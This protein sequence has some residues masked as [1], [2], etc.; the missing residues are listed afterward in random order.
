MKFSPVEFS[1][2]RP[3]LVIVIILLVTAAFATQFPRIKTDTDPNN[4][5]PENSDVRLSNREV[6]QTFGLHKDMM[7]VAVVNDTT[8]FNPGTVN[9]IATLTGEIQNISGVA[10]K[11][12][13]NMFIA[14]NMPASQSSFSSEQT[15]AMKAMFMNNP[16]MVG[17]FVSAD[18]KTTAVYVPLE[19]GANGKEV[20]DS[21]RQLVGNDQSGDTF[22]VAGDP[23]ARDTFG[24]Q[25]FLQMGLFSP[26][27]G[28]IMMLVL[29]L[30]F[31][32]WP[33]T[34]SVMGVAMI[35]I[36]WTLGLLIGLGYPVH[37]MSSMMP[38]FLMA[39]STASIHI[40]NEF[41]FCCG[42]MEE[43]RLAIMK[44]MKVVGPPVLFT[45]LVAAIGFAVLGVGNIIPV[46]VFGLF[47][48]FGIGV[49]ALLSFTF[50]PAVMTLAGE[51]SLRRAASR[52]VPERNR[53]GAALRRV[54]QFAVDKRVAVIVIGLLL[55]SLSI[56]GITKI[57]V[58]NNMVAWFKSGSDIRVADRVINDNL[59]GSSSAYLVAEGNGSGSVATPASLSYI[60]GLQKQLATLPVVGNTYSIA[61][62]VKM[63]NMMMDGNSPASFNLPS[64]QSQTAQLL[65]SAAKPSDITADRSQAAIQ[66]QLKT[67]DASAMD[68]VLD[69]TN[70]YI[71]AN[72]APSGIVFKPAGIAYFNK[73]WND[74]V[75]GDM[76]RVFIIGVSIIF[77]VLILVFRSFKWAVVSF[78][79]LLFTILIIYGAIG[80]IGKDLDMPI[81]VLS[82]LS[83][84]LA[85]DF[86][87]H[88][89]RR[90]RQRLKTESDIEQA[91]IWTV[92]RPGK[93]IIR[94]AILFSA[95]FSVMVFAALTPYITVG[96]FIMSIMMV[97]ALLT[98]V[99]LPAL[100]RMFNLK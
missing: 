1:V 87:I 80:F 56:W 55:V 44:T 17:R 15:Q 89:V 22:Y 96:V 62:S 5:L 3:V 83:L 34:L 46:R 8:V 78:I 38:V 57:R 36:V 41:Y 29:Y 31:R 51:R 16:L 58:N 73:I 91:L 69:K 100:I 97:S 37:I 71:A 26:I 18:E 92:A 60:E 77:G 82:T 23:V 4:M 45:A 28:M 24:S 30:M 61:D 21:I 52:E 33:L 59:G 79:P 74:E 48:A 11:D 67:W 93:G 90:Y 47:V 40:F 35:S 66:I 95:A 10:G 6:E 7:A 13:M 54:G 88:F 9:R 81:A 20:A 50:L 72:P 64:S 12:V 32:N 49:I 84:G 63:A 94:N 85:V 75:L 86:A 98:I 25:M 68:T 76:I 42:E 99:Y 14:A 53:A 2:R 19:D 65:G 70:S 43:R 27:A 39:I